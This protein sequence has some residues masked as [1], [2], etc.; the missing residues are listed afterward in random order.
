MDTWAVS[1]SAKARNE[2]AAR[3]GRW[4]HSDLVQDKQRREPIPKGSGPCFAWSDAEGMHVSVSTRNATKDDLER[5][6]LLATV[7]RRIL[8]TPCYALFR[9]EIC[10]QNAIDG[11]RPNRRAEN[12][13]RR[14]AQNHQSQSGRF[15]HHKHLMRLCRQPSNHRQTTAI[16]GV[17]VTPS[18]ALYEGR[19]GDGWRKLTVHSKGIPTQ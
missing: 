2:S 17:T 12:R 4:H 16:D 13:A 18:P 6:N 7:Q 8:S 14:R 1:L 3:Q 5:G 10:R 11:K 19:L 9:V 15:L